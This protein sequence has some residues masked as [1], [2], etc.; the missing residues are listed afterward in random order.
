MPRRDEDE[1]AGSE[2]ERSIE[3]TNGEKKQPRAMMMMMMMMHAGW[4]SESPAAPRTR[5]ARPS[6]RHGERVRLAA[7][8]DRSTRAAR[9]AAR[10]VARAR[11]RPQ[12]L[13]ASTR[14]QP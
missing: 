8:I 1:T 4:T 14:W 11:R 5:D 3:R 13:T 2:S 7:R 12:R 9:S 6:A 10:V